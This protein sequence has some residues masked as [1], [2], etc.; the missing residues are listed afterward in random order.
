M[1]TRRQFLGGTAAGLSA[2]SLSGQMPGLFAHA[3]D[4]AA[5][6]DANDRV[7]VVIELN[8]EC[9]MGTLDQ[10]NEVLREAVSAQPG[11][12]LVD[13][14]HATFIDSLTLGA[15]TAAANARAHTRTR[16]T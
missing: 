10:L 9:D 5:K 16:P 3:A 7:L 13:L 12:L 11:E 8:G 1:L 6:R 4:Q 14:G 15:L 2:L